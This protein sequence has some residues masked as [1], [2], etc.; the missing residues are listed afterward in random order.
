MKK[1]IISLALA[2][3][4]CTASFVGCANK[5]EVKVPTPENPIEFRLASGLPIEDPQTAR[6]ENFIKEIAEKTNGAIKITLYPAGQLG[7]YTT[8]L[9]EVMTGTIEMAVF[10]VGDNID[11]RMAL[12][13]MTYLS[14]NYEELREYHKK[15]SYL[16]NL[17]SSILA[18]NNIEMLGFE[19]G[20][21]GGVGTVKEPMN[22]LSTMDDKDVVLR[23]PPNDIFRQWTEGMN[24]SAVTIPF[25]ELFTSMQTG[26][27]DGWIGGG[28]MLNYIIFKDSINYYV[29]YNCFSDN[30]VSM[31]NQDIFNKLSQEQQEII[32]QAAINLQ[33]A[34]IDEAIENDEIYLKKLEEYGIEVVEITDEQ[35]KELAE[36][37]RTEIWPLSYDRIGEEVFNELKEAYGL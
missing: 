11:P 21:F 31:I 34:S 10:P 15:D 32:Q 6:L 35:Y 1:K 9:E 4:L 23:C 14:T 37:T 28:A 33:N 20:G 7:D 27:V 22:P 17:I 3:V 16:F 26:I 25:S 24:Y 29:P 8:I 12:L 5:E 13:T 19:T 18:E 30:S 36:Y 2:L